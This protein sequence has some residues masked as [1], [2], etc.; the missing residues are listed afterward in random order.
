M[1]QGVDKW[2]TAGFLGLSEA[3]VD[4]VYGHHRPDFQTNAPDRITRQ[5]VRQ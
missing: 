2:E 3:M 1:Q 4:R 5:R